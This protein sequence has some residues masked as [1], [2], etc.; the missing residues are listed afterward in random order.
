PPLPPDRELAGARPARFGD[1]ARPISRGLTRHIELGPGLTYGICGQTEQ[2][3]KLVA[4]FRI[5]VQNCL[6]LGNLPCQV[7]QSACWQRLAVQVAARECDRFMSDGV[8][9]SAV[10]PALED[11]HAA[12]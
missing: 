1:V 4:T 10:Q 6:T 2:R 9:Q 12:E 8:R 3:A 7:Q 11:A 5:V